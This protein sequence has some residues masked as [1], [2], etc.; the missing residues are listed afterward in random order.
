MISMVCPINKIQILV[1]VEGLEPPRIAPLDPKS[2]ASANS[3]TSAFYSIYIQSVKA[4]QPLLH[5][6]QLLQPQ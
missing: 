6:A 5:P 2:N 1:Q 4:R 3:A